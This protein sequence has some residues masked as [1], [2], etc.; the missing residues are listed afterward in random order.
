LK[1]DNS[2]I[3]LEYFNPSTEEWTSAAETQS[4]ENNEAEFTLALN[5]LEDGEYSF[6]AMATDS[7]GNTGEA[8]VVQVIM[9]NTA[10]A[11]VTG[12]Q[13]V[14]DSTFI[15]FTWDEAVEED[16]AYYVLEYGSGSSYKEVLRAT[17]A[18][19]VAENL[20][21]LTSYRYYRVKAVDEA[22]NLSDASST[23]SATT[24]A[25]TELPV[26]TSLTPDGGYY[27][28]DVPLTLKAT[29]NVGVYKWKLQYSHD[30]DT[31]NDIVEKNA[32]NEVKEATL[33][34]VW[35]I[36][37]VNEG[38][39]YVRGLAYDKVGNESLALQTSFV[40]DKT[41]PSAVTG[42]SAEGVSGYNALSWDEITAEDVKEV[43]IYRAIESVGS[44]SLLATVTDAKVY[45]DRSTTPGV[46]YSYKLRTADEAGNLSEYSA[47]VVAQSLADDEAPV[48]HAVTPADGTRAKESVKITAEVAD[49]V[50]VQNVLFEYKAENMEEDIWTEMKEIQVSAPEGS[51]E[52][53]WDLTQLEDMDYKVRI[54]AI[55]VEGNVTSHMMTI[56]VDTTA[57]VAQ[58]LTAEALDGAVNLK[59]NKNAET[60]FVYY[61]VYRKNPGAEEY[62]AV[63]KLTENAFKDTG[64]TNGSV[65]MY[66]YR[67]YD[68]LGNAAWSNVCS[69]TPVK[70]IVVVP[71]KDDD[72]S[73]TPTPSKPTVP[74]KPKVPAEN[75]KAVVGNVTYKITG[76]AASNG[77]VEISEIPA[78]STTVKIPSTVVINGYT[79]K[80]TSI[81]ANAMK[82]NKKVTKLV[83]GNNV[84]TIGSGA[85]SGCKKLKTVT[86]GKNVTTIG[87][88]AFYNC[89]ALTKITI[90]SKVT[91][92]GKS[93]FQN[94]KKLKSIVVKSTKL[95]SVGKNALKGIHKKAVIK[96]PKKKLKAY[97]KLFKKK[98]QKS[99]V[100][101]KK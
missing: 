62:V 70:K 38:T 88:K 26:M 73:D 10:I 53:T 64:L 68:D 78:K 33:E 76:S 2:S 1:N 97:Q 54:S 23:V 45:Y 29:D 95:K 55:D 39:V 9:D 56:T 67:V 61:E 11:K 93:I 52:V 82:N 40:V 44:Y 6:R 42:L 91:K 31:W 66:K 5:A 100:K 98:G 7:C 58:T 96:V 84:N 72:T 35:N 75:S 43:R 74:Q 92:L 19:A 4:A 51:V 80:V 21:P 65:Y 34:Y 90:P 79:F 94:C 87:D 27:R 85:F 37:T 49:N 24:T 17:T 47:E 22:G 86:I 71:D 13:A 81:A 46:V 77:T 18:E 25:D 15:T 30:E 63:A 12:L 69:V 59:W 3:S 16:L 99:T 28:K 8:F 101:I 41:A 50:S 48:L 32:G 57:P 20:Y 36:S 60:D 89:G 14:P 83:I